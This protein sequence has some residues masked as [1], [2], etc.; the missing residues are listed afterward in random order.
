MR[1]RALDLAR[2]TG[3][4]SFDLEF[5]REL[6]S[7]WSQE[8]DLETL[9][10][11]A[12]SV[13]ILCGSVAVIHANGRS[14]MTNY[15]TRPTRASATTPPMADGDVFAMVDS[16]LDYFRRG[17]TVVTWGGTASDFRVLHAHCL[18]AGDRSRAAAVRALASD[19]VDIPLCTVASSGHMMG[20]S[21]ACHA[22][23][24]PLEKG[25]DDSRTVGLMWVRNP[26]RVIRHCMNDAWATMRVYDIARNQFP[27][28]KLWWVTRKGHVR[29]W[30]H[31]TFLSV[32]QCREYPAV[33]P[34]RPPRDVASCVRWMDA[35]AP[36]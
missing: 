16:L 31:P 1:R 13:R 22:M 32:E 25:D 4:V 30:T 5:D 33:F 10:R 18:R 6:P 34:S 20:L 28:P 35:A 2:S 29:E 3:A 11:N 23:S 26:E 14:L 8:S 15:W 12:E 19:H 17:Y 36:E 24:V 27:V 9:R 21:A 7:N